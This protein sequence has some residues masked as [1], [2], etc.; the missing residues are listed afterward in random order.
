[1]PSG[2]RFAL[3][4]KL[5]GK[6][7]SDIAMRF[8]QG[9][10]Q[11]TVGMNGVQ[12]TD[13]MG[14][15]FWP[16]RPDHVPQN[17]PVFPYSIT[18]ADYRD[19]PAIHVALTGDAERI[20]NTW[21]AFPDKRIERVPGSQVTVA[22]GDGTEI[23]G[24][25]VQKVTDAPKP[26]TFT[27]EI[28]VWAYTESEMSEISARL[29]DL[30]D[31]RGYLDVVLRNGDET[32]YDTTLSSTAQIELPR[33]IVDQSPEVREYSQV[34][35]YTVEGYRDNSLASKLRTTVT[36]VEIGFADKSVDDHVVDTIGAT[37]E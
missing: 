35:T 24:F 5:T 12:A 36:S 9:G 10:F 37:Q 1:M 11:S 16:E 6:S 19:W 8:R 14:M 15:L 20:D 32:S 3:L 7:Q 4:A 26:R 2:V 23:T 17:L 31:D 22:L 18:G 33:A 28:R 13:S 27:F 21:H 29:F 30:L 25:S 34:L